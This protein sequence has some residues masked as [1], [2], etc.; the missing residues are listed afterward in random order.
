MERSSSSRLFVV[1]GFLLAAIVGL[2]AANQIQFFA[3]KVIQLP[4][5]SEVE[6]KETT[7]DPKCPSGPQ[8]QIIEDN[9]D[10][11]WR[12]NRSDLDATQQA[13][14]LVAMARTLGHPDPTVDNMRDV[15]QFLRRALRCPPQ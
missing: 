10:S 8:R 3:K 12:L 13:N 14:R 4:L 2:I 15:S 7:I 6:A 1:L 5:F 11:Y 9:L